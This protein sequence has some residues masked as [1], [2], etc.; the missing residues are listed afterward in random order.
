LARAAYNAGL[1]QDPNNATGVSEKAEVEQAAKATARAKELLQQHN[2]N[3]G[4]NIT[5]AVQQ[6]DAYVDAAMALAPQSWELKML[7]VCGRACVCVCVCACVRVCCIRTT[8]PPPR[9]FPIP[10][11][12]H[13]PTQKT[14]SCHPASKQ[15][16]CLMGLGQY[17]EALSLSNTLMRQQNPAQEG[18]L[19]FWRAQ[20]LY[21]M[22]NL[23][24]AGKHLQQCLRA[25]PDNGGYAALFKKVRLL[26]GRK[27]AGDDAFKRGQ[28]EAA[29]EAWTECLGV[30]PQLSGFNAKLYNNRATAYG[31]LRRH[32]EAVDDCGQAIALEPGYV[33]AFKR[34]AES[35]YALGGEEN[36]EQC[37]RDWEEVARLVA[38]EQEERE[39]AQKLRQAKVALKRAKR[40][41]FYRI[42][43]VAQDA[44]E[45]EVRRAYKKLAL[46]FHVRASAYVCLRLRHR[47]DRFGG[48]ICGKGGGVQSRDGVGGLVSGRKGMVLS[49]L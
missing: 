33:K 17:E 11:P 8:T 48:S 37:V 32:Q 47:S 12:A 28:Y 13:S 23:E 29:V 38:S 6:A 26:E 49:W 20:C 42:L 7:K 4:V 19:L 1:A 40:K 10:V 14:E 27:K 36:L 41:D 35:L 3:G 18:A 44:T 25:D 22:G 45:D 5:R 16:E 24:S 43:G 46:K 21:R 34:R 2:G 9:I 31:K 39:C 15:M 30:D